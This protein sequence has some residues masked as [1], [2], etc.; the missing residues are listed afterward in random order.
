MLRHLAFV[1]LAP[2]ALGETPP[3]SPI[4]ALAVE[5]ARIALHSFVE[6]AQ[7]LVTAQL[8]DGTTADV[9]RLARLR[10]AGEAA[11]RARS[12]SRWAA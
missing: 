11:E 4:T 1:L 8:A 5:P 9:T 3:S 12:K 6:S 7:V 2:L 10:A